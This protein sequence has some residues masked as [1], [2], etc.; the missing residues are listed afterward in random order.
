MKKFIVF[1]IIITVLITSLVFFYFYSVWVKEQNIE[2]KMINKAYLEVSKLHSV[3]DMDL[4]SGDKQ[5]YFILG[6]SIIGNDLLV[7]L[8][9][10]EVNF[11][12]LFNWVTKEE[13]ET[14]ALTVNPKM[15][16]KRITLGI[17]S[18]DVLI[19]EILFEDTEGRLGYQYYNL[20]N[21]EIIKTYKLGKIK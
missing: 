7:W 15:T 13:I 12:Y 14:K 21:G 6:K 9:D 8:N 3:V 18:E 17:N 11:T 19:Y 4:F 16:I 2:D 1:S 5:Y 20:E 10:E